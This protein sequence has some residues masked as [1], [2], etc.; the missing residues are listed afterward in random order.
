MI[1]RSE[2]MK[3]K[4]PYT[5]KN[6]NFPSFSAKFGLKVFKIFQTSRLQSIVKG[7]E[8]EIIFQRLSKWNELF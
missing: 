3:K 8:D 2:E 5:T 4:D 1:L 7:N 6:I